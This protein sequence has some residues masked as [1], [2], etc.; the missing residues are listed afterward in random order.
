MIP[1]SIVATIDKRLRLL[2]FHAKKAIWNRRA[3]VFVDVVSLQMDRS[4][5]SFAVNLGI[6]YPHAY[7]QCFDKKPP[8]VVDDI[9]CTARWRLRDGAPVVEWWKLDDGN[10]STSVVRVL[11]EQTVSTMDGLHSLDSL[12]R[13]LAGVAATRGGSP[14]EEV[15]RAIILADLG[16]MSEARSTLATLSAKASGPWRDRIAEVELRLGKAIASQTPIAHD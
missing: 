7:T 1:R 13:F 6:L 3:G 12:E 10:A 9:H 2:G 16:R 14:P 4:L 15:Y 11:E 5:D 8:A